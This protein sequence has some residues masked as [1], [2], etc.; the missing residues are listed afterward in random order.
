MF[1]GD[2]GGAGR[3][4]GQYKTN[5]STTA[6]TLRYDR[7]SITVARF[8]RN[9]AWVA[10]I[11]KYC[12][13]RSRTANSPL[14]RRRENEFVYLVRQC[15]IIIV[16]SFSGTLFRFTDRVAVPV[17]TRVRI[18]VNIADSLNRT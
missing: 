14:F 12:D 8:Y 4:R 3:G 2:G 13:A 16:I 10:R 9:W 11:A 7:I 6:R 15:V 1:D 5:T 17:D 18:V